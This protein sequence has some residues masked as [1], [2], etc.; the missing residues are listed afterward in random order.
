MKKSCFCFTTRTGT[1]IVGCIGILLAVLSMVPNI[2]L[3]QDHE[4]YLGE[5]VRKQRSMGGKF[6]I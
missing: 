1:A 2:M 6:K 3:L 4:F 5:F